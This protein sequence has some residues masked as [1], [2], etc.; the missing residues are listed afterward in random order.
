MTRQQPKYAS[1][2][3]IKDCHDQESIEL[4]YGVLARANRDFNLRTKEELLVFII[5]GKMENLEFVNS[6]PYRNSSEKPQPF[7]DAYIQE[8]LYL[9]I[10]FIVY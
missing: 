8:W 10:H 1:E 2:D 9:G 4:E 7:C 3:F 5:K 6:I